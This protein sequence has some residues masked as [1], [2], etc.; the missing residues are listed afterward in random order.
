MNATMQF[1]AYQ[2]D[3][4]LSDISVNNVAIWTQSK[5]FPT[6]GFPKSALPKSPNRLEPLNGR[7]MAYADS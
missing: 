4:S 5:G 3:N 7:H 1:V 2:V 6:K